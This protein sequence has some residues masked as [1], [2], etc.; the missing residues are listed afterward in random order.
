MIQLGSEVVQVDRSLIADLGAA[1]LCLQ[2][3]I[4]L[5]DLLKEYA[6]DSTG[7]ARH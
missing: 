1:L 3:D 5:G 2:V 4:E 7:S 6:P